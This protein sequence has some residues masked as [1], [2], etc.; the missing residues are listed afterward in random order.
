MSSVQVQT[1]DETNTNGLLRIPWAQ[2]RNQGM[3][4]GNP[5]TRDWDL[6]IA[7]RVTLFG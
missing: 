1:H 5:A 4:R 6:A 3:T 7:M 2:A